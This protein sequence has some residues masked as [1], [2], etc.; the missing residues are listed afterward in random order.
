[1]TRSI[2]LPLAGVALLAPAGAPSSTQV[3]V[4]PAASLDMQVP[5]APT[6]VVIGGRVHLVYEVHLTNVRTVDVALTG[7]DVLAPGQGEAT[8]ATYR[9]D[10]LAA[11]LTKA[12]APR[13]DTTDTRLVE[14]GRRAVVFL[15]LPL[16]DPAR[17]PALLRHRVSLDVIGPGGRERGAAEGADTEVRRGTPV[18]LDAPVRGG[19]WVAVYD[20]AMNGG[21]RR[22]I[23]TMD[24]RS[25]IPARFGIDWLRLG[26]DG[27]FS[28][29][30]GTALASSYSYGQEVFAV[31][32][33]RVAGARDGIPEPTPSVS[34]DNASGNYVALDLG[35]GRFAFYEHLQTGSVK[36]RTGDT[37]R[38]GDLIGR[39]G[40]SGS[41]SAGPHLHFHVADTSS[42]LGAEGLPYIFRRYE[43]LGAFASIAA[44][45]SGAPWTPR[46]GEPPSPRAMEL[47]LQQTVLRF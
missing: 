5:V 8:I 28:R 16:D 17:A 43:R 24:G 35:D 44:L 11:M 25:R 20:H 21:H 2:G 18:A 6:P 4:P 34:L 3:V 31:A 42:P 19:P 32:D 10:E 13:S 37:V 45:A 26:D 39:V 46:R 12:G 29:D 41:V 33:A 36:V 22:A 1:M 47:P 40:A 38:T 27:R 7:V 9:G 15:W 23:Y 14:P 30:G